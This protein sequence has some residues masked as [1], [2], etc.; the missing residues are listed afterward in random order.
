MSDPVPI[1]SDET[2]EIPSQTPE[3]LDNEAIQSEETGKISQSTY[4]RP[5]SP[6]YPIQISSPNTKPHV[7][8]TRT[9]EVS[10]L[11]DSLGGGE[12]I[13]DS[14]NQGGMK[15]RGVQQDAYKQEKEVDGVDLEE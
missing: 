5:S 12:I 15:T 14:D 1:V 11:K 10:A 13:D 4:S 7:N 6:S 8:L 9:D 3:S 2:S